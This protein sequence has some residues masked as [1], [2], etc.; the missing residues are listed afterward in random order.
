MPCWLPW[1]CLPLGVSEAAEVPRSI[2]RTE[3][4]CCHTATFHINKST[5]N[6]AEILLTSF[7]DLTLSCP[8]LKSSCTGQEPT[9][10]VIRS[11]N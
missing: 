3:F 6:V 7:S 1:E 4:L 2:R 10:S 8:A 11:V 9:L 5:S